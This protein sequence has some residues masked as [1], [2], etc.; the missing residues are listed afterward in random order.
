MM[1]STCTTSL[2]S[3]KKLWVEYDFIFLEVNCKVWV[4]KY[5]GVYDTSPQE[6]MWKPCN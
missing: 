2:F 3:S 1:K 6:E 4:S 5:L